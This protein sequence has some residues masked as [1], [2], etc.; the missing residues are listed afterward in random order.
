[1]LG[2]NFDRVPS[3]A[4]P[5]GQ[6]TDDMQQAPGMVS[7]SMATQPGITSGFS[8]AVMDETDDYMDYMG[9]GGSPLGL[10][11]ESSNQDRSCTSTPVGNDGSPAGQG[12]PATTHTHT[13]TRTHRGMG[14]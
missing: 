1:M 12:C 8:S 14:D 7:G 10:S 6:R 5:L 3:Q 11:S 4:M 13:H 9:G 2:K